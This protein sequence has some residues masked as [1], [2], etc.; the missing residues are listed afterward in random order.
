MLKNASA[1]V[2]D[3]GIRLEYS[4]DGPRLLGNGGAIR[5]ALRC[6][7]EVFVLYGES[8]LACDYRRVEEAFHRRGLPALMRLSQ[9]RPVRRQQ[10]DYVRRANPRVR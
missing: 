2:S 7:R 9:R 10:R 8:Y 6:C 5:R 3:L 4:F 1:T